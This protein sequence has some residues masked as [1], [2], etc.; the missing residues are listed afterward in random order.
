VGWVLGEGC[1]AQAAIAALNLLSKGM[2]HSHNGVEHVLAP[3]ARA[4]AHLQH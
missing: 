2:E 3:L 4:C 1:L